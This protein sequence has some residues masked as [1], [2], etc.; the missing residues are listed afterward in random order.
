[1]TGSYQY[2]F[3]NLSKEVCASFGHIPLSS[4]KGL[5]VSWR[6]RTR[7]YLRPE[8]S[9]LL[10][11]PCGS[12]SSTNPRMWMNWHSA[13]GTTSL[14]T[15]RSRR[16]PARAGWLGSRSGRAAGASCQ[17]TTQS[18]PASVTPGWDT[19]ECHPRP[20]AH[21]SLLESQR[22]SSGKSVHSTCMLLDHSYHWWK[23]PAPCWQH[24]PC[25]YLVN[26][27]TDSWLS[28]E[29]IQKTSITL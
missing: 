29:N 3:L 28:T 24:Y 18:E 16:K 26:V 8:D 12:C 14:W 21:T 20:A 9:R 7:P 27:L 10:S 13:L 2:P 15:P 19:G 6:H 4:A 17:R 25:R 22:V 1:M 23:W 11:R 5:G